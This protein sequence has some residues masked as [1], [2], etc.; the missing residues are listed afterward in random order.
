MPQNAD[1][2]RRTKR[3]SLREFD[4][5]TDRNGQDLGQDEARDLGRPADLQRDRESDPGWQ[6]ET[7]RIASGHPQ[8]DSV[9]GGSNASVEA[10]E[11]ETP[12]ENLRHIGDA[13]TAPKAP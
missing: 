1:D 8:L 5:H 13:S 11:A 10:T 4:A 3:P 7:A 12:P 2:P 9:S 6:A